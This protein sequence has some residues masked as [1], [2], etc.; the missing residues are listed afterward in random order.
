MGE[1][2]RQ[3]Q[4]FVC[5]DPFARVYTLQFC[6]SN[7]PENRI[8]KLDGDDWLY[9]ILAERK[10]CEQYS[11][12][13]FA[14]DWIKKLNQYDVVIG[15]IA[16]DSM[17]NAIKSF[18]NGY[19]TNEALKSCLQLVD[20]GLQYVAKT[21]FACSQIKTIDE[22][23]LQGKERLRAIQDAERYRKVGYDLFNREIAK[24]QGEGM[25][26]KEFLQEVTK[27]E[28]GQYKHG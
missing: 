18:S 7:I 14:K 20:Y 13:E 10:Y 11:R 9:A 27:K 23:V 22:R 25:L 19:I 3:A 15:K 21:D 5:D 2:L 6:L 8:L 1:T 26:I 12:T 24:N 28:R 4:A 16:D 17:V